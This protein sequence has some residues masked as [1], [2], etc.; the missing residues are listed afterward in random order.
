MDATWKVGE[1]FRT[2][3][4][5]AGN[6]PDQGSSPPDTQAIYL[7]ME[8]LTIDGRPVRAH[9]LRRTFDQKGLQSSVMAQDLWHAADSKLL[10]QLQMK[11]EGKGLA[12][13]VSDYR[14]TA[15]SLRPTQ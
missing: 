15:A 7:G 2:R 1:A 5:T 6:R 13:F 4:R 3:C 10:V 12:R 14:L 11:G 8:T 9:R